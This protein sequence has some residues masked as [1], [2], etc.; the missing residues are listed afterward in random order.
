MAGQG[1]VAAARFFASLRDAQNDRGGLR[2]AQNDRGGLRGAQ[3]DRGVL[4]GAQND[5]NSLRLCVSVIHPE[6]GHSPEGIM[7]PMALRGTSMVSIGRLSF[8]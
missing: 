8:L 2:D 4:R 6:R 7:T 3:N 1:R 5:R